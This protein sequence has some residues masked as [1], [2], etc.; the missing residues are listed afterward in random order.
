MRSRRPIIHR[1][2][3]AV[4]VAL[5]ACHRDPTAG[6]DIQVRMQNASAYTLSEVDVQSYEATLSAPAIAPGATT[7]YTRTDLYQW[8]AAHA[9]AEGKHLA[10]LPVDLPLRP[11]LQAPG[12]YT[13]RL[14]ADPV[15]G[16]MGA[17]LVSDP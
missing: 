10:V 2:A 6:H 7:G 9:T 14:T 5:A 17:E 8:W 16:S 1:A 15:H 11:V 3:V 12:R 4:L 13:I